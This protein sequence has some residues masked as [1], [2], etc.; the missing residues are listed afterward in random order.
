M[1]IFFKDFRCLV[2]IID[3]HTSPPK[4]FLSSK[5]TFCPPLE[6]SKFGTKFP[7]GKLPEAHNNSDNNDDD[8]YSSGGGVGGGGGG[9][10][11]GTK[12]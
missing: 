7:T 5:G 2:C 12:Q 1:P 10:G 11:G 8:D 6:R 4:N 3:T 9:G